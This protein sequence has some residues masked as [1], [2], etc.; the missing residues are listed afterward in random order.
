[1]SAYAC[2]LTGQKMLSLAADPIER[3]YE[4]LRAHQYRVG[5]VPPRGS[6]CLIHGN[7]RCASPGQSNLQS[8]VTGVPPSSNVGQDGDFQRGAFPSRPWLKWRPRIH[9]KFQTRPCGDLCQAGTDLPFLFHSSSI[10]DAVF[11][12]DAQIT[13]LEHIMITAAR[14]RSVKPKRRLSIIHNLFAETMLQ[15]K[16][17][18]RAVAIVKEGERTGTRHSICRALPSLPDETPPSAGSPRF[19]FFDKDWTFDEIT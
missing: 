3:I 7:T 16:K 11:R 4:T 8:S 14:F 19:L 5:R 12:H 13:L 1:M 6:K 15:I 10:H 17:R 9:I 18:L 2:Q